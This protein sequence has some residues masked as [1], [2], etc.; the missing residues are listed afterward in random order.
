MIGETLGHF[1]IVE[2]VGRGGFGEVYKARDTALDRVVALKVI[3]SAFAGDVERRERFKREARA[4]SALNHPNVCTIYELGEFP[5]GLYIAMEFVDGVSLRQQ[6]RM[7]RPA[8]DESLRIAAQVAAAMAA[9]HAQA[10]VHRDI[11]PDN[12]LLTSAGQAK[13]VDFGLATTTAPVWSKGADDTPTGFMTAT[14]TTV[15]TLRYMS[16]EQLLGKPVGFATDLF[17]F[18]VLLYEM[19]SGRLPFA[20]D[21]PFEVADAIIH[22]EPMDLGLLNSEA[23]VSLQRLIKELLAKRPDDRPPSAESVV[24]RLKQ[25]AHDTGVPS[26]SLAPAVERSGARTTVA[27]RVPSIAVLPFADM[28]RDKENEYFGDGLAEEL[29]SALAGVEGLKV[30]SRTSAFAFKR[31]ERDIREIARLLNVDAVLEGSVRRV[32]GRVRISAQ[33][34]KAADGFHLWAERFDRDM[35]DIFAL[36][37][38]IAARITEALKGRLI[39]PGSAPVVRRYTD[40]VEAYNLY[41]KGRYYWNRR[42]E[43]VLQKALE[44]FNQAIARAPDYAPA[45]SGVADCFNILAFYFYVAPR[46]GFSKA[47]AA[48]ERALAIDD[49]LAEAHSSLGLIH[50]FFDWAFEDGEREFRKAILLNPRYGTAHFWYAMHEMVLGRADESVASLKLAC[51]AEPL[52]ASFSGAVAFTSYFARRYDEAIEAAQRTLELEPHFGPAHAYLAWA[53][54]D[55][56]RYDLAVGAWGQAVA[57]LGR[58]PQIVA[59]FGR[60]HALAGRSDEALAVLGQLETMRGTRYVSSYHVAGLLAALGRTNE[61]V[62]ELER[63]VEERNNWLPFM[64]VDPAMDPLRDDARFAATVERVFGSRRSG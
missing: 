23:P 44:C 39:S 16:P 8:L 15:G 36:Q 61:A 60:C 5:G 40:D 47:K 13:V 45:W 4:A 64:R 6:L 27:A 3:P 21:S 33:L 11:K 31:Q 38:E 1:R 58:I 28:S 17:S 29:T 32:G 12:V 57:V 14:G 18:G 62:G 25:A 46:D 53:Y 9:A 2:L 63:A 19:V 49:S 30:A 55:A 20:G 26:D 59:S 35:A 34:V 24:A 22:A 42:H 41:L 48:A 54:T 7:A 43:G 10:I 50:T 37:D 56:G 51:E 52:S